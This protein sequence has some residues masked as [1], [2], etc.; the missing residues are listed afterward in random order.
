MAGQLYR[1]TSLMRKRPPLGPY[2]RTMPRD[3]WWLWG[4][5]RFLMSEVS[6]YYTPGKIAGLT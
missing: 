3:I 5:V 4:G 1:G 2:T 6:L